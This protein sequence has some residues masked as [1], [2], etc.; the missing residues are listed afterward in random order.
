[1]FT[2]VTVVGV[3]VASGGD[4]AAGVVLAIAA[5]GDPIALRAAP[6]S[7]TWFGWISNVVP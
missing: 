5:V 4:V 2:A 6:G 1:M 7:A 3:C